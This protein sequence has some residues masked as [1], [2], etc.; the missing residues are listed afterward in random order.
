VFVREETTDPD[1]VA[2]FK[3]PF[4]VYDVLVMNPREGQTGS[5]NMVVDLDQTGT[6][7]PLRID[8]AGRTTA[9]ERAELKR[10]LLERARKSLVV[11]AR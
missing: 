6:I 5:R 9:E 7:A 8:L 10:G 11:W 1:G 3:V 4:G 2:E